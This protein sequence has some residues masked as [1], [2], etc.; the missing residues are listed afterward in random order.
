[1]VLPLGDDEDVVGQEAGNGRGV[2]VKKEPRSCYE[3]QE[4]HA[5]RAPLGD[6]A[7]AGVGLAQPSSYDVPDLNLVEKS[8]IR[9]ENL[10]GETCSMGY[11][12]KQ[13]S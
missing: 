3:S 5:E 1:M 9:A 4:H 7:P 2:V 13:W 8:L 6:G 12:A 10:S 11:A